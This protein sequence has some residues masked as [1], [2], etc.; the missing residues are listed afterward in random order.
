MAVESLASWWRVPS[1]WPDL[2]RSYTGRVHAEDIGDP[3]AEVSTNELVG[4]L[5]SSQRGHSY[6]A[7]HEY[8]IAA[9]MHARLVGD[10]PREDDLLLKD[11][12][13]DCAARVAI[14]LSISQSEAEKQLHRAV[15][16]RDRLPQVS[17]RLKYGQITV[18]A[19]KKI[20]S[21]TD[22]ID[23]QDCAADVDADIAAEL[24]LHAGA[25]SVHRLQMMVDRIVFRHDPDAVRE[26]RRRAKDARRFWTRATDDGMAQVS[27]TMTAENAQIADAAVHALA[28]TV[29]EKDP[30]TLPQRLSDAAF[31]SLTGNPFE[32]LCGSDECD[33]Q[34]PEPGVT[35]PGSS[36]VIHVVADEGTVNGTAR[37]AGFI[38]GHGVIS[39]EHVRDLATRPDAVI[40]P[41]VPRGTPMN[42]DGTYTVPA[43]SPSNPYRPSTALD[44]FVRIRDGYSV[45]PGDTTS[46]F[47]SDLDH[48]REFDHAD[49]ATGGQTTEV[50]LNAKGRFGHLVKTF[51]RWVD[52]QYREPDT[53][54]LRQEFI[55]PE[56]LVIPGDPE[57]LEQLLPGLRRIRFKRPPADSGSDSAAPH[58]D[59]PQPPTRSQSRVASKHVRRQRERERN[60]RRREQGDQ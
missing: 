10:Q 1:P 36:V 42:P 22:L 52:E 51:G 32:C 45:I 48:V 57:N 18:D 28:N 53:G 24:D 60:R 38:A 46:S 47:D 5:V 33:A 23:G 20:I 29:C 58:P 37:N 7:W 3:D 34:I 16:L 55:T 35:P 27:A 31:A 19:V 49:P 9:E 14:A 21:R 15:S 40:R 41:V 17:L 43:Y 4:G 11:G 13:A 6:L 44:T 50:N 59:T 26:A 56:G 30:R 39:D 54:R 8:Q 12:F 2:P 25:W